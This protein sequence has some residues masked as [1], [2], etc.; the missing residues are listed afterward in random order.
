MLADLVEMESQPK[1]TAPQR[2]AVSAQALPAKPRRLLSRR[3]LLAAVCQFGAIGAAGAYGTQVEPFWVQH[4]DYPMPLRNLPASFQGFRMAQLT[5]L[6]AGVDVP[7]D[8]LKSVVDK[9]VKARPDLVVITGDLVTS[10]IEYANP[11]CDVLGAL[12]AAG[13]QSVATFGN[14][15]YKHDDGIYTPILLSDMLEQRLTH[16]G[17][18]VLRNRAMAITRLG[19]RFWLV[20]LEDLWS[21]QFSPGIAFA[22]VTAGEPIIALSHNPDTAP[23]LDAYGVQWILSGHT[24]GGQ[25]RVPGIG[26]L[27]VNVQNR[28][29]QEGEYSLPHSKLYISRGVGY[30]KR[31]RLM[32][33]PEVPT[34]VLQAATV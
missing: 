34:F 8:Y 33:R 29:F 15:D 20:G 23:E 19:K 30:L 32:C 31:I 5:D 21:G 17:I 3:Q 1:V 27:L 10:S 7:M 12:P 28:Q 22:G 2:A 11:I 24:H 14:H 18:T 13:I 6:H 16:N 4:H 25:V 9:V 26:A